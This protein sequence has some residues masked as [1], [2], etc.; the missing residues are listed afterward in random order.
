MMAIR[1]PLLLVALGLAAVE[2]ILPTVSDFDLAKYGITQGGLLIVVILLL[3]FY[4]R[5]FMRDRS[6]E[7]ERSLI[8]RDQLEIFKTL[9]EE[10]TA[11]LTRAAESSDRVARAVEH[12]N[13][14]NRR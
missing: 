4:R 7:Q 14:G 5:D 9:V 8:S 12:M 10:S 11:A 13:N 1:G 3:F 2:P 6:D